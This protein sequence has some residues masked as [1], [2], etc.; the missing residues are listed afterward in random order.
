MEETIPQSKKEEE[1]K[2]KPEEQFKVSPAPL[3]SLRILAFAGSNSRASINKRLVQ[4]TLRFFPR[5]LS[6]LIDLNDFEMPLFS[7]D[8]EKETGFPQKV[9]EFLELIRTHD[10]IICSLA[11]H[12]RS[13]TVAFKNI[14]DWV[15]R[16][17][18]KF[19]MHKPMFLLSTSPGRGGGKNV[20]HTAQ[21]FFPEFDADIIASFSLPS[22][23]HNF[24]DEQ[25]ITEPELKAKFKEQ[26]EVLLKRL[27]G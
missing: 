24:S 3:T 6:T 25:G 4:Y 11:E 10:A 5:Q 2:E 12:N 17:D 16:A 19:F 26:V 21:T 15:S 20:M 8:R 22:F 14:F 18:K 27:E 7:I 13:Y 9:Y 23:T 1:D